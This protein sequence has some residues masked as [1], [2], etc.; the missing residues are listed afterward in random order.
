MKAEPVKNLRTP[1]FR[2]LAIIAAALII[3]ST[4]MIFYARDVIRE[5]I[6]LPLSYIFWVMG[7]I[8]RVT[9]Q[10]FF[11]TVLLLVVVMIAW[12]ALFG[13]K[14]VTVARATLLDDMPPPGA[15][16]RAVFWANK[17]ALLRN[18]HSHYYANTFHGALIH[19]LLDLLSYRYHLPVRIIEDQLKANTLEV[20]TEVREYVL[21][22]Y[23][24]MEG[25]YRGFFMELWDSLI[26]NLT[27]LWDRV[28]AKRRVQAPV[29]PQVAFILHYLEEELE[30]SH[31][32]S[33]H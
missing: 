27:D 4:L 19:L 20:P 25:T 8:V 9:P 1:N 24:R 15:S 32:D 10:V 6:V 33:G 16:G 2:R 3:L 13:E 5:V 17:V 30:V 7:I 22:H 18:S 31:D 14:K 23:G 26:E 12:R 11:W 29:D 28:S 21:A